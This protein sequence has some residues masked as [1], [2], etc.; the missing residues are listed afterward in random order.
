MTPTNN[1]FQVDFIGIGAEKAGTSWVAKCLAQ[2]PEVYIPDKK[3][4]FFFNEYDPHY[5]KYQNR[6]YHRGLEW[7]AKQFPE[8]ERDKKIGEFTST[9]FCCEQAPARIKANFP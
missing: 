9:Y 4:M 8:L 6:K 1:N 5:L 7:Y 2:H 3:E